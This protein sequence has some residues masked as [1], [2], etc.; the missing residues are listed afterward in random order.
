[1]ARKYLPFISVRTAS[2]KGMFSSSSAFGA[3]ARAVG[4]GVVGVVGVDAVAGAG[5][6]AA[7]GADKGVSAGS[8]ATLLC[9]FC[10]IAAWGVAY[11]THSMPAHSIRALVVVKNSTQDRG[12]ISVLCILV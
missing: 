6:G 2:A 1:M 8:D 12:F 4:V 7:L 3:A 10:V 5:F 9:A 11:A